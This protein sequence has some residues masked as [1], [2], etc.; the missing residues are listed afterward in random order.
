MIRRTL[1]RFVMKL[2]GPELRAAAEA[3]A[4]QAGAVALA[5]SER[6]LCAALEMLGGQ[7]VSTLKLVIEEFKRRDEQMAV[8][9]AALHR[10]SGDALPGEA[11]TDEPAETPA[12]KH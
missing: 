12:T 7:D 5:I 6:K 4:N 1:A 9:I 3:E 8:V 11:K 2:I 10:L